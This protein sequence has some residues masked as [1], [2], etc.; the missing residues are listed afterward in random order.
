MKE[1]KKCSSKDHL[2]YNAII[3]C[4]ICK[5]FMCNKC[6]KMH[7]IL[8]PDHHALKLLNEYIK[9]IF[10]GFCEEENHPIKLEYFCKNHNKLCCAICLCKIK[11]EGKGQHNDCNACFI[12]EIESEK[13]NKLNDNIK[14]L[15]VLSNSLQQ[16]IKE[17]K[18]IFEKI[19]EN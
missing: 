2:E 1:Q 11:G 6:E 3:Y 14:T 18:N 16:T 17:L 19:N 15:E 10:T 13:K 4:Q 12:K 9:D 7:S 5:K 8:F